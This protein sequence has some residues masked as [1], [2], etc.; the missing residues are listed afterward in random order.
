[1][2]SMTSRLCCISLLLPALVLAAFFITAPVPAARASEAIEAQGLV[3]KARVTFNGFMA[4]KNYTWLHQNLMN[5]QGILIYPQ[6]LKA[7]FCPRRFRRHRR[8]SG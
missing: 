1:M 8:A 3:D 2:K 7:G 5:A 6:V 4:D